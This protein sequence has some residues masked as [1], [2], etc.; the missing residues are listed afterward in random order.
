VR[1]NKDAIFVN[2]NEFVLKGVDNIFYKTVD[3]NSIESLPIRS[4]AIS[5]STYGSSYL[6]VN[7]D[8]ELKG[9]SSLLKCMESNE[10]TECDDD[11][12][13]VFDASFLE[14][15]TKSNSINGK[16]YANFANV[17]IFK[18]DN[19]IT[20]KNED[21]EEYSSGN[22]P[23]GWTNGTALKVI[24]DGSDQ[25]PVTTFLG[26]FAIGSSVSKIFS[27]PSYANYEIEIEFDFYEIDTW[28]YE[29]FIVKL[30]DETF[31][32]D[33]FIHDDHPNLTDAKDTGEALQAVASSG[34][35]NNDND[36]R[37]HY[38]LRS[39]LDSYGDVK[40]EFSTRGLVD[41][42]FGKNS[43]SYAQGIT[44]ESWGIDNIKVKVKE[45]NKK[46][47]CTMTGLGSE[48]QLYCW[49]NTARSIPILSTS[50]YDI[51]KITSKNINKLF[52]TQEEDKKA[53]MSYDI[54]NS[55]GKLFLRFPTYIGGFD[56]GFYFK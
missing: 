44:D 5:V 20:E 30:N 39:K 1:F 37:Y 46:F 48:S 38:K 47:V 16:D 15:N 24:N 32:E 23:I 18:L 11:D 9:S 33:N 52:I 25:I 28:D 51:S 22:I 26:N 45:T 49:G 6:Y 43:W 10:I 56:Y 14:L 55:E 4:S 2:T 29:K 8:L 41:G 35:V 40:I 3:D 21:F 7:E 36:E 27:F 13:E 42:D 54:Y 17:S 50:L 31:V 53:Q 12:K 34:S 19:V